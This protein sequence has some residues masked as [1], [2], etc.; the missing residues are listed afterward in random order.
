MNVKLWSSL[1]RRIVSESFSISFMNVFFVLIAKLES[2][3]NSLH[4]QYED[5]FQSMS[6]ELYSLQ[7]SIMAMA[8]D[9]DEL[10]TRY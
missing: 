2:E 10:R 9:V 6:A 7:E 3:Y 1:K 8:F 4:V 5:R